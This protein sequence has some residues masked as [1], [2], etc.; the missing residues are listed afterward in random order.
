MHYRYEELV[1]EPAAVAARIF[2][3]LGLD[4][5]PGRLADRGKRQGGPFIATPSRDAVDRPITATA[6]ARWRRYQD[7]LEP[8]LPILSDTVRELGYDAV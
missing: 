6:V 3:F 7:D 8:A 5:Q 1:A 4:W 2:D